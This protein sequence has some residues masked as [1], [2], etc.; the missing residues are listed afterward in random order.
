MS[1]PPAFEAADYPVDELPTAAEALATAAVQLSSWI[2]PS[3]S[4]HHEAVEER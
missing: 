1:R 4:S 3:V 2:E